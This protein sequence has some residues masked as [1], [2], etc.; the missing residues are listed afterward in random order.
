[1]EKRENNNSYPNIIVSIGAPSNVLRVLVLCWD[2]GS[3]VKLGREVDAK[4]VRWKEQ[5]SRQKEQ[6]MNRDGVLKDGAH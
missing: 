5:N 1:M 4:S 2:Q 3:Q 6:N